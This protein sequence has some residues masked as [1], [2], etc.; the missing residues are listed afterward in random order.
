MYVFNEFLNKATILI[1]CIDN[2]DFDAFLCLVKLNNWC[3]FIKTT[4]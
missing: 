2:I 1:I 4:E 3:P